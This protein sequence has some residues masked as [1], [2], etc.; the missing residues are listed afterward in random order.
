MIEGSEMNDIIYLLT[1]P[2]IPD[3]VKIGKTGN[4]AERIRSLSRHSGI[5]VPFE[6]FYAC[7]VENAD[8]VEKKL[9]DAF[10]DH[11]VNSKREFFRINPER[12]LAI[13]KLLELK[14]VTPSQDFV[15]DKEDQETLD[16]ERAKRSRFNFSMVG[17]EPGSILT[18]LKD[19]NTSAKVI[20]NKEIE[21]EGEVTSLSN[22]ALKIVNRMGYNWSTLRGPHYWVF[23][24][25]TL[26]ERRL[27]MELD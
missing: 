21:F 13:L 23:E 19:E 3:L 22:A 4:L 5:P 12:I 9:H 16:R 25:E 7:E 15:E 17:L 6:C 18:F 26:S 8:D 14:D 10:G 20:N 1:N 24:G 11:R 2:S 27:R